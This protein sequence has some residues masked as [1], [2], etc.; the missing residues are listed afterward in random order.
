MSS[1][2]FWKAGISIG[3]LGTALAFAPPSH[4]STGGVVASDHPLASEAGAEI[5]AKGGNAVDATIAA[6]LAAGV[7][8]LAVLGW[9]AVVLPSS[10]ILR[11]MPLYWIFESA[12]RKRHTAICMLRVRWRRR[13]DTVDWQW[14]FPMRRT[15]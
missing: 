12:P 6:V 9:V 15:A 14:Q 4:R 7:V 11:M 1:T 10:M 3:V 2:S 13:L 5:L 8:Q